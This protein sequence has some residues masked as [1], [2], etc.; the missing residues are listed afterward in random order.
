MKQIEIKV[1]SL[2]SYDDAKKR[3]SQYLYDNFQ[4]I[5]GVGYPEVI[6]IAG[7]DHAGWT[8]EAQADR[9]WS[10][11]LAAKVIEY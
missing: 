3:A 1:S 8:A 5:D 7:L 11:L 4:I 6:V 9:L 10:G 2:E